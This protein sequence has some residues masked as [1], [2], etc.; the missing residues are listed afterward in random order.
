MKP[1][2]SIL[3]S[4]LLIQSVV[5]V[6]QTQDKAAPDEETK[7]AINAYKIAE[8]ELKSVFN[9]VLTMYSS[10]TEFLKNLRESQNIW[11][12]FRTAELKTKFP[13]RGPGEYGSVYT[14]CVNDFL[15]EMTNARITTLKDWIKGTYEGDVC[16]GSVKIN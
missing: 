10:D 3:L 6:A 4:V 8:A 14:M 5:A 15:T 13:E 11:V 12:K 1:I 7:A 2:Y 9:Q 16:S